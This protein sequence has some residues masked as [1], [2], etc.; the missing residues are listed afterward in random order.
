MWVTDDP[1]NVKA[2][3][4]T[5]FDDWSLGKGRIE[6]LSSYLG[7]GIFTNEGKAWKV[8]R[9][10]L[11]PC[12][13]K[14]QVADVSLL[15]EHVQRFMKLVPDDG[16]TVD[17]QPLL[18]ELTLDIATEFLF[19]R[20]TNSLD[21]GVESQNVKDFIAAFEYCGS[22]FDNENSKKYGW[23]GLFLPDKKRKICAKVIQGMFLIQ[24]ISQA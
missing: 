11:R 20:S 4:S 3:L 9:E 12:F 22:P 2:M 14:R 10:M 5:R 13:E 18:H 23:L 16:T 7:H 24:V 6:E 17:L 19:G 8:S 15:E 1:E 21:R